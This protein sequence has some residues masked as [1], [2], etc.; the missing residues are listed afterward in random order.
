MKIIGVIQRRYFQ[1]ISKSYYFFNFIFE[2]EYGIC[3]MQKHFVNG[4][5]KEF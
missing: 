4:I 5:I 2:V 3:W 1:K